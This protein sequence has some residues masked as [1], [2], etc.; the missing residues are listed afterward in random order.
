MGYRPPVPEKLGGMSAGYGLMFTCRGC[1]R[2][3]CWPMPDLIKRWG[4]EGRVA[5]IAARLK[6]GNCGRR[7]AAI[8]TVPVRDERAT[9][10]DRARSK[11]EPVD[12]LMWD[13][14]R[15]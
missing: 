14:E 6:C 9:E 7:G 2:G 15:S 3:V 13:L 1:T 4:E 12:R 8:E 10:G 11:L 5:A